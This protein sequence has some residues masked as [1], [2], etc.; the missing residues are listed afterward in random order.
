M[1]TQ[2]VAPPQEK[3][4]YVICHGALAILQ[5]DSNIIIMIPDMERNHTYRAGT[6]LAETSIEKGSLNVLENVIG[7]NGTVPNLLDSTPRPATASRP[8]FATF[9]LPRPINVYPLFQV[10][11][12]KEALNSTSGAQAPTKDLVVP[13]VP[14]LEYRYTTAPRL[15]NIWPV[16]TDDL[17]GLS[18]NPMTLHIFA[19]DEIPVDDEHSADAFNRTCELLG[20]NVAFASQPTT[21]VISKTAGPAVAIPPGLERRCFEFQPLDERRSSLLAITKAKQ[22]GSNLIDPL[23]FLPCNDLSALAKQFF[24]IGGFQPRDTFGSCLSLLVGVGSKG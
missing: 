11:I 2:P 19:E 3:T 4:L 7:G 18:D 14:V 5:T 24:G 23:V 22:N 21:K 10:T 20:V 1:S 9:I 6:W 17:A 15:G 12:A 8:P 13:Y 16:A